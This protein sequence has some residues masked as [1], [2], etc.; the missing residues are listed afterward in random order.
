MPQEIL[1]Q[2][3]HK[4]P[5]LLR[6]DN[7]TTVVKTP[8][9]GTLIAETLKRRFA[10][11][12]KQLI[13]ESWE[14]STAPEAPSR[15]KDHPEKTLED[16]IQANLASSISKPLQD[17]GQTT[18]EILIKLL[19]PAKP[20]SVQVHPHD[21][22]PALE[23]F[24]CGKPES[25]LIL[26]AKPGSGLY[27]GFSRDF[28]KEQLKKSLQDGTF[29]K[30]DLQFVPV[31]AG[32]YFEINP[33]VVH[34]VGPDLLILE[35]QRILRNKS[36]KTWRLWDWERKYNSKGQEVSDDNGTARPLNIS[37]SL[38]MF[39]PKEQV[40]LS[41][42]KS[43]KK[44]PNVHTRSGIVLREYPKNQYYQVIHGTSE[45]NSQLYLSKECH[46]AALTLLTGKGTFIGNSKT[47]QEQGETVFLPHGCFPLSF[48][49]ESENA[50]WTLVIPSGPAF[51]LVCP[52]A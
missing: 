13:G 17:A 24:E 6:A 12:S 52:R 48:A 14:F 37:E 19:N 15:L 41:F 35:P 22:H 25:W 47:S 51:E 40:G 50:Q 3:L 16:L 45:K 32:D 28:T 18:A 7:F 29:S 44:I 49:T 36:G 46:Y 34:A 43:L 26:D 31:Q 21:H 2:E 27:L 38:S 33:G 30:E 23:P 4:A 11:S 10:T 39:D 42:A 5:V 9:A 20:L 1:L 8:W